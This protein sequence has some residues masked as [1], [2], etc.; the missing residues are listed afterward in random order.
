MDLFIKKVFSVDAQKDVF[1]WILSQK[2]PP[3]IQIPTVSCISIK[4]LAASTAQTYHNVSCCTLTH[5][6]LCTYKIK[7]PHNLDSFV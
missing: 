4:T 3:L 5:Y 6:I 7:S 1:I 2:G